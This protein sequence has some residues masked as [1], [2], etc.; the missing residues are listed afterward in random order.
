MAQ[1]IRPLLSN[2]LLIPRLLETRARLQ[3]GVAPTLEQWLELTKGREASDPRDFINGGLS[4][5]KS[6]D[7]RINKSLYLR[8]AQD[9]PDLWERLEVNYDA[10]TTEVL[11]NVAACLLSQPGG[12]KLLSIASRVRDEQT[13]DDGYVE[14][15]TMQSG[16][17][18]PIVPP[19]RHGDLE[20]ADD[21]L[22]ALPSWIPSPNSWSSR[23][24]DTFSSQGVAHLAACTSLENRPQISS[25]GT[26]LHID[27]AKLGVIKTV[28]QSPIEWDWSEFLEFA[29]A[30]PAQYMK[31]ERGLEALAE[32]CLAGT[33]LDRPGDALRAFIQHLKIGMSDITPDKKE[34][35]AA[36]KEKSE[37]AYKALEAKYPKLLRSQQGAEQTKRD[38]QLERHFHHDSQ[39]LASWR[40]LFI[41]R[42]GYLGLGPSWLAEGDQVMLVKGGYVPYIFRHVDQVLTKKVRVT[43]DKLKDKGASLSQT[44]REA[45]QDA[46]RKSQ[47]QI[48]RK[49]A[50]V[51][52]GEAYVRGVMEGQ[53]VTPA[54]EFGRVSVV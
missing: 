52:I 37:R 45:L 10:S 34:N 25:D 29:T 40:S 47:E 38:A 24:L 7:L 53:A 41:T 44:E 30:V 14:A 5:L 32:T 23:F 39:R 4:L 26:T 12:I 28:R 46:L 35:A 33:W 18:V 17:N 16:N 1:A 3:Q 15:R 19:N 6:E 48:G 31:G 36:E 54:T 11:R 22:K 43:E 8:D 50:W 21:E 42:N 13:F 51:L 2:I 9:G 49:D 20:E 27:A